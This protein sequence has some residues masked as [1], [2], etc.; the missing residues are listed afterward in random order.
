MSGKRLSPPP[1]YRSDLG[2]IHPGG[3]NSS[4]GIVHPVRRA[5]GG[6][7]DI[8]VALRVRLRRQSTLPVGIVIQEALGERIW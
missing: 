8:G 5:A 1:T 2:G 4:Q 6:R 7:A 3:L